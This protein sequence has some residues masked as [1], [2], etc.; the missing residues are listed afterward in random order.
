MSED[1]FVAH[2]K[3]VAEAAERHRRATSAAIRARLPAVLDEL[4]R[5]GARRIIL[6]GSVARGEADDD[7]DLDLAVEGLPAASFFPAMAAAWRVADRPVDL[8]RLEEA[9]ATLR[10]RVLADGEV[11]RNAS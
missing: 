6:F 10:D 4:T 7:S 3:R 11:V 1:R 8:V 9:S 2:Q 5:F